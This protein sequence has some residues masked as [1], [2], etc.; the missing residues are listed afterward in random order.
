MS[1]KLRLV[2]AAVAF[3]LLW[4]LSNTL[5]TLSEVQQALIVR[6]GAPIGA[7]RRTIKACCTSLSV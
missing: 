7:P 1:A 6:L 3:V 5:Y 4:L 2:I